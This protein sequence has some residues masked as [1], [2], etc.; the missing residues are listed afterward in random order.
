MSKTHA[1]HHVL[2]ADPLK[3]NRELLRAQPLDESPEAQHTAH[4][5]NQA[6]IND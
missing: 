6:R 4:M 3:D 5:V 1:L 2:A